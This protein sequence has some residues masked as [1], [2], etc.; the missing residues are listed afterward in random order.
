MLNLAYDATLNSGG[1]NVNL[2]SNGTNLVIVN[3]NAVSLQNGTNR[4]LINSGL[5]AV[6]N[7]KLEVSGITYISSN[8]LIGT[9][10]NAGY[11][12][13]V[14]GKFRA[15][16][17]WTESSGGFQYVNLDQDAIFTQSSGRRF[18]FN[19]D[20]GTSF[21]IYN[22]R[23]TASRRFD[24]LQSASNPTAGTSGTYYNT[25]D[26][27]L[28]IYSDATFGW[29]NILQSNGS[30]VMNDIGGNYNTRIEGDTDT[31]LFFTNASTDRVGIGTTS[32]SYKL[33]VTGRIRGTD[34]AFFATSSGN[35]GI[36][37][38][39]PAYKLDVT[40]GI[41]STTSAYF[42]TTSGAVG[43]G[44]TSP[45]A[46]AALEVSSTTKGFLPPVMT[47]AQAE[48]ISTPAAGLLVY[49]NNGNGTTITTTG[50]WGYNGTT[51]VK[52]N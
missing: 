3:S 51:W 26:K 1:G 8:T 20:G 24:W 29:S 18:Q 32:P 42:A 48:A 27:A 12:L 25:T 19:N 41:R 30:V 23:I 49:A 44:T 35:V 13:D 40:G 16:S 33:D 11:L 38:V 15:Q 43:I 21:Q 4:L 52:L 6:T 2:A 22:D 31:T 50:W 39:A 46:S 7:S 36:G 9:T 17:F 37:N 28:R 14:N 5:G 10:T 47:G 34:S 45:N